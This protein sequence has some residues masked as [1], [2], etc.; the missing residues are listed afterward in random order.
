MLTALVNYEV[1]KK[2]KQS[3]SSNTSA[4][5]LVVKTEIPIGRAK[6]SVRDPSL[7]QVLE[8]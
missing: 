8:I 5:A 3:S 1:K 7:E 2:D 6:A 4:E